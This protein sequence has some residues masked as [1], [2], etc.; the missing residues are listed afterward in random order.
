MPPVNEP[1]FTDH[2]PILVLTLVVFLSLSFQT[3]QIMGD[4]DNLHHLIGQQDKPLEES[5]KLQMQLTAL[6]LGTKKLADGGNKFAAAII[7]H[8]QQ[9]GITIS[10]T[11]ASPAGA[12]ADPSDSRAPKL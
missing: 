3:Y 9:A 2:L 11:K 8:M 4:R 10:D 5:H 12:S 6:A 7:E 1:R